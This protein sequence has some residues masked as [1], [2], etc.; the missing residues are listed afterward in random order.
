MYAY[1]LCVVFMEHVRNGA[2]AQVMGEAFFS[3]CVRDQ[4]ETHVRPLSHIDSTSPHTRSHRRNRHYFIHTKSCR[5]CAV[6][7]CKWIPAKRITLGLNTKITVCGSTLR[8]ASPLRVW[9]GSVPTKKIPIRGVWRT[10]VVIMARHL[11]SHTICPS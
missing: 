10:A 9:V 2:F 6:C 4:P 3:C 1:N 7:M 11:I 8:L 5:S